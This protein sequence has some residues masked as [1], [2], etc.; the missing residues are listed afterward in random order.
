MSIPQWDR[1]FTFVTFPE[2]SVRGIKESS[3]GLWGE[4]GKG[5]IMTVTKPC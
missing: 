2:N 4:G 1:Y 3:D 5:T